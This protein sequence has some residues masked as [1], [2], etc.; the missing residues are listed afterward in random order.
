M[1][2]AGGTKWGR[3]NLAERGKA[4]SAGGAQP[5]SPL[6]GDPHGLCWHLAWAE[7]GQ[8]PCLQLAVGG[9]ARLGRQ[10]KPSKGGVGSQ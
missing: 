2:L 7:H 10:G 1:Q 5:G 9:Q 8:G 3:R 4:V 6:R